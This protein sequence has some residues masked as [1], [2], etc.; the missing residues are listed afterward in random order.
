MSLIKINHKTKGYKIHFYN[1][2]NDSNTFNIRDIETQQYPTYSYK[3]SKDITKIMYG[4]KSSNLVKKLL[5]KKDKD[6]ELLKLF[7]SPWKFFSIIVKKKSLDFYCEEEEQLNNWFYGLKLFINDNNVGYKIISTNKFVLNKIKYK[8][9]F[10]LKEAKKNEKVKDK[11]KKYGNIIG[12]LSKEIGL[13]NISF[14]KLI[15]LYNK[16]MNQ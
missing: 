7:K 3:L 11:N 14:A 6:E 9:V 12:R 10:K 1:I 15:L 5:S 4:V 13:H 2:D 16:L 8:I